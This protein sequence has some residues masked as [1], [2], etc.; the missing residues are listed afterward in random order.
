MHN[1][2][3]LKDI[4]RAKLPLW[5]VILTIA[6]AIAIPVGA[7]LNQSGGSG[8]TISTLL[9]ITSAGQ[10]TMANSVPVVIAS[11]QTAV[12][13]TGTFWQSTQPVSGTV[14]ANQGGTWTV[15]PGNTANTTAWLVTGTGGTFPATQ[16][17]TWTVRTV[18][19][20]ACGT[21]VASSA[22]AAVP[23]TSAAVFSSTT[24]VQTIVLNNTT[25]S[26]VTVT[27]TD[28]QGTPINDVLTFSIPA[29][30]QLIQNVGGVAFT[31]GVKWLASVSGVTGAVIGNQ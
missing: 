17:G 18:P 19:Q 1:W 2:A 4:F 3:K 7:Q 12:P 28:N 14:T 16:S 20:N 25:G 9:G 29:Y 23:T 13:V 26:P 10:A 11:N 5:L 24:C 6:L 30:S 21:T 15:Q 31:T 8:S 22:L 27:V